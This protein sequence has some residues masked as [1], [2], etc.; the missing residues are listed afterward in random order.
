MK[1]IITI[2]FILISSVCFGQEAK[3]I[4]GYDLTEIR[5][6]GEKITHH[7]SIKTLCVDGYK[8]VLA[9]VRGSLSITQMFKAS[10]IGAQPIK[11]KG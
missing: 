6:D 9:Y 2:A 8:Y 10:A 7:V 1:T 5:T 11:C 3:V 4:Q